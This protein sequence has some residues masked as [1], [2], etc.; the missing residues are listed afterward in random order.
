[1]TL[2]S[3]RRT[4]SLLNGTAPTDPFPRKY[5]VETTNSEEIVSGGWKD[6]CSLL[7]MPGGRDS[8]YVDRLRGIGNRVIRDFVRNGGSYL[9]I[10]AGGYYA[11]SFVEF[12]KGNPLLEV[13]GIRELSFFPGMA[14]G[15]SFP[16]FDYETNAGARAATIKLTGAGVELMQ[17]Y[18]THGSKED[19][20]CLD[21]HYNGGCH[22]IPLS[23][24]N[25]AAVNHSRALDQSGEVPKPIPPSESEFESLATYTEKVDSR[26]GGSGASAAE[27]NMSAIV[28]CKL[29]QGKAVLSGVHFEASADLLG[30]CYNGDTHIASLQPLIRASDSH[31]EI[32]FNCL[33]KYLLS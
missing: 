22:F 30:A 25:L 14:Q 1:M 13:I 11:T 3:L 32:L 17:K 23:G 33:L 5:T 16:G 2:S 12:A 6:S 19:F 21:V 7:V 26:N 20:E 31:R 27:D 29:G 24:E 18:G 10:C 15:P 8:P 4:V 28:A 9:G